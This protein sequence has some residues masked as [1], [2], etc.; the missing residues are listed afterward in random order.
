M[1]PAR[2]SRCNVN[3]NPGWDLDETVPRP[4]ETYPPCMSKIMIISKEKIPNRSNT[5]IFVAFLNFSS[6]LFPLSLRFGGIKRF[7]WK[8]YP[9]IGIN[10]TWNW[11][12]QQ[13][14]STCSCIFL[15]QAV[16]IIFFA[17]WFHPLKY[18]SFLLHNFGK[19]ISAVR[20][21][22]IPLVIPLVIPI[23]IPL[24]PLPKK[25]ITFPLIFLH[26]LLLSWCPLW[27]QVSSLDVFSRLMISYEVQQWLFNKR[28]LF[29]G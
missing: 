15:W 1:I 21:S 24:S 11:N 3:F 23:V 25:H 12:I 13:W 26:I 4:S 22:V 6:F 14:Y 5:C 27:R 10:S 28:I 20:R 8:S 2:D 29:S 18:L 19:I 7:T 16:V 9:I 17:L